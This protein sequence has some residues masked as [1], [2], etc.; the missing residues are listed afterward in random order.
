MTFYDLQEAYARFIGYNI[1][2][3]R[4]D[5]QTQQIRDDINNALT[6]IVASTAYLWHHV[7]EA[8]I[9]LVA[10]TSTYALNDFCVKPISFWTEDE[11]AHEIQ[12]IDP[13]EQD[14]SGAKGTNAAYVSTGP[15]EVTWSV[16]TTSAS[17]SSASG[18]TGGVNVT[19]GA[20]ALTKTGG[21]AW[22][23]GD[24]G[25]RIRLNGEDTDYL[26]DSFS[27]AN[28]ISIDRNYVG[29]LVGVGQTGTGAGLT[30]KKWEISPAGIYQVQFRPT[31]TAAKTIY[32]RYIKSHS[33]MSN[34]DDNPDLPER[35]HYLILDKAIIRSAKFAEDPEAYQLYA[36]E[37]RQGIADMIREDQI[38]KCMRKRVFYQSPM[39]NPY[40]HRS[41]P[42]DIYIRGA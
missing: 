15:F 40:R 4:Q 13:R 28:S 26:V 21:T 12:F 16:P 3:E 42:P 11:M 39:G 33:R 8:T 38:E 32:Y 36:N 2:T 27:T 19:E 41:L 18:A 37:Y 30:T 31:P 23:S 5:W 6:E 29:R 9:T 17:K 34:T 20:A 14:A 22:A 24:V 35:Y 7:R 10:N 1:S 25:K